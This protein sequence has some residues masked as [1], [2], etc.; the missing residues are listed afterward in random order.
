MRFSVEPLGAELNHRRRAVAPLWRAKRRRMMR[1]AI[2]AFTLGL[3]ATP[4]TVEAQQVGKMY[5]VGFLAWADCPTDSSTY[6]QDLRELGYVEGRNLTLICR[7]GKR[8]YDALDPA[9]R[10]L[11]QLGVDVIA[12]LSHPAARAARAATSS[13]PIVMVA[14]GDPVGAG[15]VASLGHPGGNVTGLTYYATEL[16]RKRL[17]LLKEAVPRMTRVGVLHNPALAYLPFLEDARTAAKR[18][19]LELQV[20]AVKEPDDLSRAFQAFVR[21][22][23]Q[24][25]LVLPDLVVADEQRQLVELA[26]RHKLPTMCW[27]TG[28]ARAGC[29]ISYSA[30]YSNLIRR[31]A[32]FADKILKGANPADL[33]VEQPTRFVLAVNLNT[34]KVLGIAIP[35][36]LLLQADQ[37]I[38]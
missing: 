20:A 14:S 1:L 38:Q 37:V 2:L 22:E 28:F 19:G 34:A 36:S 24:A 18:L 12:A 27:T 11:V 5:R 23:V 9:A 29:L 26:L 15:L 25:V 3:I 4:L 8:R 16:T 35:R 30:D 33:P 32:V 7:T 31:A 13:V 21:G 17:Q 10:E 6:L